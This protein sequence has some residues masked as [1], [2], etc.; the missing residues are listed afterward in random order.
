MAIAVWQH[1]GYHT[2]RPHVQVP[3]KEAGLGTKGRRVKAF[4]F[5][6]RKGHLPQGIVL[7][8]MA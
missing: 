1:G 7:T 5:S 4:P 8:P 2:F 3:G 6:F